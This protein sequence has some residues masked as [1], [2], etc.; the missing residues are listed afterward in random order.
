MRRACLSFFVCPSSSGGRTV[1]GALALMSL[2]AMAACGDNA[3][4]ELP[5]V[6]SGEDERTVLRVVTYPWIPDAGGDG[7][8][9]LTRFI[10]EDF[11]DKFPDIDLQLRPIA[12]SFGVYDLDADDGGAGPLTRWLTNEPTS[13][14]THGDNDGYHLVEIDTLLLGDIHER[15]LIAEWSDIDDGDWH[16]AAKQAV[17]IDGSILGVPRFLCGHFIM[18][19]EPAIT[20]ANNVDELLSALDSLDGDTRRLSGNFLGSWNSAALYIDAWIDTYP[21]SAPI[22]AFGAQSGTLDL[23]PEVL[24]DLDALSL[25]CDMDG[26]NWCL[27]GTYDDYS[28]PDRAAKEFGRGLA[29]STFGYSERL[30]YII[31][32][33]Q[34][35]GLSIDDIGISSVPM[36]DGSKPILFA[37]AFVMRRDCDEV[38]RDAAMTFVHYMNDPETHE[39]IMLSRDSGEDLIPRYLIPATL[40]ALSDSDLADDPFYAAIREQIRDGRAFPNRDFYSNKDAVECELLEVWGV[41]TCE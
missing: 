38:C 8:A 5:G 16:E 22:Q 1:V 3:S 29:A 2:L 7:F 27:D 11:E 10:E 34:G 13:S 14:P 26:Q 24:A 12:D 35:A 33:S 17:D 6:D 18:S 39:A 21:E 28:D 40:S 4:P 19:R 15:G 31:K 23:D 25:R 41:D 9:A 37:D 30:H 20:A 36:G 32:E